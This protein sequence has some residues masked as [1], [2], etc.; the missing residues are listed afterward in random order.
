MSCERYEERIALAAGGDLG[1]GD[2]RRLDRHL[3]TCAGCRAFAEEMRQSRRA[4]RELASAPIGEEVL[5]RVRAGVLER[6]AAGAASREPPL[7]TPAFRGPMRVPPRWLAAAAVLLAVLGATVWRLGS[8]GANEDPA[9]RI[10]E[11]SAPRIEEPR[12]EGT[13]VEPPGSA[14]PE[15]EATEHQSAR[16]VVAALET[17]AARAAPPPQPAAEASEAESRPRIAA[18]TSPQADAAAVT[19]EA[20]PVVI[21][22]LTDDPDVVIYWLV[23]TEQQT[24]ETEHEISEV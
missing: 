24:E 17:G 5:A 7:R 22:W 9:P 8:G 23:D 21:H 15:P 6:I 2:A 11:G 19:P 12:I 4:V 16:A 18:V 3:A 1:D 14:A 13:R 20:A 10:V